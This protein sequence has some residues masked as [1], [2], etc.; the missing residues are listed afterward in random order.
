[1]DSGCKPRED[2][3]SKLFERKIGYPVYSAW[4]Y[5]ARRLIHAHRTVIYGVVIVNRNLERTN[6]ND[7]FKMTALESTVKDQSFVGMGHPMHRLEGASMHAF[8][9]TYNIVSI[10]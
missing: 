2:N 1:M 6:Q 9:L 10:I 7:G 5:H 3:R 8:N 4:T